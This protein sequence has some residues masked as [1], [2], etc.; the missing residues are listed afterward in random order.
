MINEIAPFSGFSLSHYELTTYILVHLPNFL[1]YETI[2]LFSYA[3]VTWR[4]VER[5]IHALNESTWRTLIRQRII[6]K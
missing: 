3:Q 4:H 6:L 1:S 2:F 5:P